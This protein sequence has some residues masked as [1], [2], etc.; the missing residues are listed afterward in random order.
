MKINVTRFT[1]GQ[2]EI[3]SS[4]RLLGQVYQIESIVR[5]DWK[6]IAQQTIDRAVLRQDLFIQRLKEICVNPTA[7]DLLED[8]KYIRELATISFNKQLIKTRKVIRIEL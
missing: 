3:S 8:D 4:V 5:P 1:N 2:V 6:E 7:L